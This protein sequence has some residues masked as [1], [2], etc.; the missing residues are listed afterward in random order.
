MYR[1]LQVCTVKAIGVLLHEE[2]M[3]ATSTGR[4]YA[5]HSYMRRLY[6]SLTP[7][8]GYTGHSLLLEEG[9][10]ATHIGGG[11]TGHFYR[12]RVQRPPQA[13]RSRSRGWWS[14]AVLHRS[15]RSRLF[16]QIYFRGAPVDFFFIILL[17]Y[18]SIY[19]LFL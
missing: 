11:Y 14:G 10:Q 4:G 2:G 12:R 9:T 18:L 3:Q 16:K 13:R 6:R 1:P 17:L 19:I 15:L 5:G 7:T 8:G